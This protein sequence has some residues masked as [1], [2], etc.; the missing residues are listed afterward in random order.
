MAYS[1]SYLGDTK[2]LNVVLQT[3][4]KK[5][6]IIPGVT[7]KAELAG[8]VQANVAEFYY[9]LAPAVQEGDAGVDFNATQ[10]GN[11]KAVMPLTRALLIDEKIPQV[12]AEAVQYDVVMDR[13]VKGALALANRLGDKFLIDLVG[14]A[15]GKEYTNGKDGYEAVVEAIGTFSQGV[16]VNV[17]GASD[18]SYTNAANGIQPTTLIVGDAFRAKLLETPAFQRLIGDTRMEIPGLIGTMLGLNVV[19]SQQLDNIDTDSGTSGIQPA[20]FILLNH[21]GVAYPYSLN[22]LRVVE[23]ELFNGV[24]VQGEIVYAD[25]GTYAI[26]PIDCHAMHFVEVAA[27]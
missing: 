19:Y 14:K 22:T 26:L 20:E 11:K 8:L 18:T 13:M 17:G 7:V 15:Q 4:A 12:A 21:E 27:E 24:R 1:K 9:D 3:I 25:A 2:A 6:A 23:S 16:S 10:K 5:N